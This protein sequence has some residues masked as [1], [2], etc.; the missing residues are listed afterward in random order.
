MIF[1]SVIETKQEDQEDE[2]ID[3]SS[4]KKSLVEMKPRKNKS[5]FD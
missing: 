3:S 1:Y 2:Q 4:K 5:P